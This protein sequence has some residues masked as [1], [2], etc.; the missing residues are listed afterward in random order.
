MFARNPWNAAFGSRVALPTWPAGRPTGRRTGAN[1]S[2]ATARWRTRRRC[3]GPA[4]FPGASAPASI[5]AARCRRSVALEAG[6]HAGGRLLPRRG[7]GYGAGTGAA[8]S[9]IARRIS[10][11]S[12]AAWSRTGTRCSARSRSRRRTVRWTSCSI[13]GCCT[14]PWSAACGRARRST[15]RAAPT[16]FATSCRMPWRLAVS[17]AALTREHLLRAASRQFTEGDVQHWWLPPTGQGVRTRISD[18]RVWLA[19]AVAHYVETA[20]DAAVL[21]ERVPFIEGPTLRPGEHDAYFQASTCRRDGVALRALRARARPESRHRRTRPAADRHR[22]L[23]RRHEPGGR[24]GPGRKRLARLVP[25]RDASRPSRRWRSARGDG[26]A[27]ARDGW[28]TRRRCRLRSSATA[29]MATGIGAATSTTARRWARPTSE[30]C[31]IDSIAQSWSVI[32][33]AAEPARATQ[34]MAARGRAA[35]P[36]R[37]RTG[38]AV[39]AAVRPHAA[40]SRLHQGLPARHTRER[41]P[42]HARG[43]LVGDRIR[44]ARDRRTRPRSCFHCS[45]RSTARPHAPPCIATR[46]NPTSSPRTSTRWRR[47][48]GAAAGRGTRAR[49][50][51]CI[52]PGSRGSSA[53][54]C[55]ERACG[56]TPCIPSTLARLRDRVSVSR[57]ALRDPGRESARR[58]SRRGTCGTGRPATA[59]RAA[60]DRSRE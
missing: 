55:R 46:S 59:R 3:A 56:S 51:G 10:T 26:R 13:A 60:A 22:R 24:T 20:G 33:G 44:P 7:R 39:H 34:A 4:A 57:H 9:A 41:R 52:G 16:A 40:R 8:A 15:R 58:Q 11:R 17:S 27:R 12:C 36:A 47:T 43:D 19:Y 5:P 28:R 14:R 54:T 30:E 53:F 6:E 32:S 23:E 21:E 25:V 50:A 2:G 31:R 49:P 35:D 38:A 48:S 45:I 37:Q 1:S 29:G 42:V 18:D